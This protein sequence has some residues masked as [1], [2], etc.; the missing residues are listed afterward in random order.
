VLLTLGQPFMPLGKH[1]TMELCPPAS[2][3]RPTGAV[4]SAFFL[5][6]NTSTPVPGPPYF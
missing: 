6:S 2:S 3:W 5:V 4:L 1:N